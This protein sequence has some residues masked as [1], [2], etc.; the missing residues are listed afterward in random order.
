MERTIKIPV[1]KLTSM[2]TVR[3]E[4]NLWQRI[5]SV[6][7][8]MVLGSKLVEYMDGRWGNIPNNQQA[9]VLEMGYGI[10]PVS[11]DW[12]VGPRTKFGTIDSKMVVATFDTP[13]EA[14]ELCKK[15]NGEI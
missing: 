10:I 8:G 11:K 7:N 3:T 2:H 5:K 4:D 15:L 13:D 6:T 14:E 12:I 1:H 9:E